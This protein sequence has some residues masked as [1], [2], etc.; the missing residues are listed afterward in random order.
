MIKCIVLPVGHF[1]MLGLIGRCIWKFINVHFLFN[2]PHVACTAKTFLRTRH[3]LLWVFGIVKVI[4]RT[5]LVFDTATSYSPR[6]RRLS[7]RNGEGNR[8]NLIRSIVSDL[9]LPR[10]FDKFSSAF[11]FCFKNW[12]I[13]YLSLHQPVGNQTEW[14]HF[15]KI[16]QF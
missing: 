4:G 15:W 3:V 16:C 10:A 7:I 1:T 11:K 2:Y 13:T 8:E 9:L 6:L 14:L 5:E 12:N